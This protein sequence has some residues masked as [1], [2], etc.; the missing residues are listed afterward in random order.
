M[1]NPRVFK[2]PFHQPLNRPTALLRNGRQK[3]PGLRP[4]GGAQAMVWW[5]LG[6]EGGEFLDQPH[7][8]TGRGEIDVALGV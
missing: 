6:H 8:N 4:K 1:I 5:L 7:R 2:D 3:T